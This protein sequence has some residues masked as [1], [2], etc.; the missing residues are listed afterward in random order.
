MK[1]KKDRVDS[2]RR[3][4]CFLFSLLIHVAL[5]TVLLYLNVSVG[6]NLE[7]LRIREAVLVSPEQLIIPMDIE[8]FMRHRQETARDEP[9]GDEDKGAMLPDKAAVRRN[10]AQTPSSVSRGELYS[11]ERSDDRIPTEEEAF[12]S[13]LA[14]NFKLGWSFKSESDLLPDYVLDFSLEFEKTQK[15]LSELERAKLERNVKQLKYPRSGFFNI[16]FSKGGPGLAHTGAG[17]AVQKAGASFRIEDYDISPWAEKV[18]NTIL[19]NWVI[20]YPKEMGVKG[21]VGVSVII[22]ESGEILSAQVVNSSLILLLDEAALKALKESSPFPSLPK[23]FPKK[24]LEAYFE[25]H[26]DD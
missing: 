5:I 26:Y 21:V 3:A 12:Y 19:A 14:S 17:G 6:I 11:T 15:L 25:F 8:D 9:G 7:Q 10:P 13:D 23:D 18:V 4:A 24:S 1:I 2:K 22:D 20:P 16:G